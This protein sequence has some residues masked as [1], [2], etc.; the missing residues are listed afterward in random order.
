MGYTP[1]LFVLIVTIF[2]IWTRVKDKS[3]ASTI[4]AILSF[5]LIFIYVGFSIYILSV[6]EP[7]LY[8]Y[9][10][11]FTIP[12]GPIL[13]I[14]GLLAFLRDRKNTWGQVSLMVSIC[15]PVLVFLIGFA[16]DSQN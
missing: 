12:C 3:K 15:I 2:L 14:V 8:G 6:L 1:L 13:I 11:L 10:S 4:L 16:Y 5:V 9:V 7:Q